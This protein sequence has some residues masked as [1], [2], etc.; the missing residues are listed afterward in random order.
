MSIDSSGRLLVG[1]STASSNFFNGSGS[2]QMQIGGSA[3][4]SLTQGV[5]DA[6]GSFCI[7]AKS[8]SSGNTLVQSGDQI[9]LISFQGNDGSEHVEAATIQAFV[10]GTP[11]TND[12]PGRLVFSTTADGSASPTERFRIGSAG[13]LGIGGATYGTSGQVLT[14]G[15]ASAA[16]TWASVSGLGVGQTWQ[17]VTASRAFGTTYTNSTGKPI[18]VVIAFANPSPGQTGVLTV[19]G[20]AI[21]FGQINNAYINLASGSAI[22][23]TGAT[24]VF[25]TS[26][27]LT[28]WL[29]LR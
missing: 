16:P 5:N 17:N 11:G 18:E 14:S 26:T 24:Y 9:G 29:E 7:F 8:R 2:T 4:V 27:T 28:Q 13:Q 1:T 25:N 12:M 22:V 6:N 15:G 20:V 3:S 19:G 21:Q 23:P 10:D